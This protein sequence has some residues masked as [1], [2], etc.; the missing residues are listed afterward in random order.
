MLPLQEKYKHVLID[1]DRKK[2]LGRDQ[3]SF[4]RP[5]PKPIKAYPNSDCFEAGL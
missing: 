1:T 5:G 3:V 4:L 2:F